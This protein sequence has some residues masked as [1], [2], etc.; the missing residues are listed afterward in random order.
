MT[1]F[2]IEVKKIGSNPTLFQMA[3]LGEKFKFSYE[4]VNYENQ[5]EFK[6]LIQHNKIQ[7]IKF[8]DLTIY[9]IPKSINDVGKY[10]EIEIEI[11]ACPDS[12]FHLLC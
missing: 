3:K 7:K 8:H 11:L 4:V 10:I 5:K 1:D 6:K 9:S 2:E 12:L